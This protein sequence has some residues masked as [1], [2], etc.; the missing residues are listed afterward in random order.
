M[1]ILCLW[2]MVVLSTVAAHS[3]DILRRREMRMAIIAAI[4]GGTVTIMICAASIAWMWRKKR[5]PYADHG[6]YNCTRRLQK[7]YEIIIIV[8]CF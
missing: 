7:S 3:S 2:Q 4:T 6:A 8:T 5:H 1:E